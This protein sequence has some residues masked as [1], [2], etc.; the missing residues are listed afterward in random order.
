MH[1]TILT[2]EKWAGVRL[3][4]ALCDTI[5]KFISKRFVYGSKKYD[6]RADFVKEACI[7]LLNQEEQRRLTEV[8]Q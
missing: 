8:A 4:K 3:E 7:E 1:S 2:H 6:S 5:D